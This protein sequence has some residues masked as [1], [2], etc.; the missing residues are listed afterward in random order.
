MQQKQWY[1]LS[2]PLLK[3]VHPPV[4]ETLEETVLQNFQE[5]ITLY[6]NLIQK[7]GK[8]IFGGGLL[9]GD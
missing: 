2:L 4:Q 6:N 9:Y 5:N 3:K 7:G 8:L 1:P